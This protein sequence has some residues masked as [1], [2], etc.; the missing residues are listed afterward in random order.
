[1]LALK[2]ALLLSVNAPA[3]TLFIRS[4]KSPRFFGYRQA[5]LKGTQGG[6]PTPALTD[7]ASVRGLAGWKELA[8]GMSARYQAP[9]FIS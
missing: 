3:L 4:R 9:D 2:V 5:S 6:P 1:M 7:T 8:S